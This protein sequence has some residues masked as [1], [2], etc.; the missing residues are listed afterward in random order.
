MAV[1]NRPTELTKASHEDEDRPEGEEGRDWRDET[2][3]TELP[4]LS[5][6][7]AK[8]EK[9]ESGRESGGA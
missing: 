6:N 3:L 1:M 4:S 5:A 7:H 2:G 8:C 9:L